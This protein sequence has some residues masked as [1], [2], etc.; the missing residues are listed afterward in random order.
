MEDEI[1]HMLNT[2]LIQDSTFT[3]IYFL[4]ICHSV[5]D[6]FLQT[7]FM[8]SN[9]GNDWYILFIHSLLYTLPFTICFRMDFRILFL[10]VTHFII[11]ALKAKYKIITLWQ[12]QS[13]HFLIII[14]LYIII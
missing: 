10:L 11:D 6:Y 1:I 13:L 3:L 8:A 9:K 4:A 14:I 5:G 12:D 2:T 7:E